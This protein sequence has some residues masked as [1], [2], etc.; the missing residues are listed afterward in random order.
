[1]EALGA[2]VDVARSTGDNALIS[3]ALMLRGEHNFRREDY[4]SAL[5][6]FSDAVALRAEK[7]GTFHWV[8]AHTHLR[9]III[10]HWAGFVWAEFSV[11]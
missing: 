4:I 3:S 11:C 1:M 8:T 7:L 5:E 10:A 2:V 9:T 6:Q